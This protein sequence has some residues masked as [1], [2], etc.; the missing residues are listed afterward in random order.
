MPRESATTSGLT[1]TGTLENFTILRSDTF[2][3]DY[4][5]A[6][7]RYRTSLQ[8]SG[9]IGE[10]GSLWKWCFDRLEYFLDLRPEYESIYD[11]NRARFGSDPGLATSGRGTPV[12]G[13]TDVAVLNAFNYDL[14]D[15]EEIYHK[16][17]LLIPSPRSPN[18]RFLDP[19]TQKGAWIDLDASTTNLRTGMLHATNMDIYGPLREAYVDLYFDALGGKN[20][21]RVGKQQHV[22][23]KADFFR[24]QD[25]VNPV[26]FADHFF[27][28]PFDDTRIPLWSALFEHRFGDVGMFKELAGSA[29]W[30][31]DR[32]T[33]L[34]FGN[35]SQPWAIG[36]GRELG[37]FAFN[38]NLFGRFPLPERARQLGQLGA[39]L[40]PAPGLEPQELGRRHEVGVAV[41]QRP[42]PADGLVRVPG[43]ARVRLEPASHPGHSGLQ[44]GAAR[45]GHSWWRARH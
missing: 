43:R 34:G 30:V 5:V 31:F 11:V 8:F 13:A 14:H 26:N 44:R 9:P 7:S 24:L 21:F 41:G 35:G 42:R 16:S 2:K 28:D 40:R 23:G 36:F 45:G 18:V 25:V 33:S 10:G 38:S 1:C 15:F 19:R 29:I 17:N 12:R 37:S 32:Y 6:S 27:I 22:W 20:W 4:H 3:D 39:H